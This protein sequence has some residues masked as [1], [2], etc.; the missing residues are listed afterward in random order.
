M[1]KS[2]NLKQGII[3]KI[4]ENNQKKKSLVCQVSKGLYREQFRTY[5]L[6]PGERVQ[7]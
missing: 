4:Y 6:E 3:R 5:D 2:L 7:N 1:V